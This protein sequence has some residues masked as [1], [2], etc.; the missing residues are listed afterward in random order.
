MDT[1]FV[2]TDV[3]VSIA[4]EDIVVRGAVRNTGLRDGADVVQVYAEAFHG[5]APARLVA[6]TRIEIAAGADEAFELRDPFARLATRD[7]E[8]HEWRAPAGPYR[9]VVGR[10]VGDR[11]AA[12][13]ELDLGG[14]TP[15]SGSPATERAKDARRGR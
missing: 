12:V 9:I 7:A 2:L 15:T 13:V 4:D 6:F 1:T 14:V 3:G 8:R 11:D 10:H 5:G